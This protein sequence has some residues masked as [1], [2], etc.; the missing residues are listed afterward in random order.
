MKGPPKSKLLDP[1]LS[2]EQ[3]EEIDLSSRKIKQKKATVIN[4]QWCSRSPGLNC[5]A[6][7][8]NLKAEATALKTKAITLE[9]KDKAK[10]ITFTCV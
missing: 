3:V 2:L 5:K 9:A 6:K 7:A 1:P 4:F 10:E 8:M